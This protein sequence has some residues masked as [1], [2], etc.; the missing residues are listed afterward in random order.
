MELRQMRAE[1]RAF[2]ES[3]LIAQQSELQRLNLTLSELIEARNRSRG[4]SKKG[5]QLSLLLESRADEIARIEAE[6]G[7]LAR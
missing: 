7:E 5:S 6:L 2:L 3:S 1:H 4:Q